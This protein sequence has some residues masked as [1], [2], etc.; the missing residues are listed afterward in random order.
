[1]IVRQAAPGDGDAP[2]QFQDSMVF[3]NT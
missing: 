1:M 3:V 2:R